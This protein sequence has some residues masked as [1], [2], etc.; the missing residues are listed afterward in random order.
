MIFKLVYMFTYSARLAPPMLLLVINKLHGLINKT[1][2]I[3]DNRFKSSPLT[4]YFLWILASSSRAMSRWPCGESY[5]KH[6]TVT[7]AL[8]LPE[9][10]RSSSPDVRPNSPLLFS[11]FFFL[12]NINS[13]F[14]ISYYKEYTFFLFGAFFCTLLGCNKIALTD[15]FR[16]SFRGGKFCSF[17]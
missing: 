8:S 1:W 17:S 14:T 7:T 15:Q 9:G 2:I 5:V 10:V 3:S 13:L 6:Y 12:W 16:H 11:A 4:T